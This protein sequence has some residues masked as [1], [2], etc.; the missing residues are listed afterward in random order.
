MFRHDA[1]F[2]QDAMMLRHG[3]GLKAEASLQTSQP[4]KEQEQ[5]QSQRCLC[6]CRGGRCGCQCAS[7]CQVHLGPGNTPVG[8]QQSLPCC[9]F[10]CQVFSSRIYLNAPFFPLCCIFKIA[11][12]H[13]FVK[14][15]HISGSYQALINLIC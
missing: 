3:G 8:W 13:L 10:A 7:P 4:R 15:C 11:F 2:R 9:L 5:L 14:S 12:I 6:G 1:M